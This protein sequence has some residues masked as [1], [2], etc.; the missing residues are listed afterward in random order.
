VET[1]ITQQWLKENS[2]L[3]LKPK[4]VADAILYSLQT[5]EYVLIKDL[6]I[7]PIR[8]I[9]WTP[10]EIVVYNVNIVIFTIK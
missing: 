10:N 1:E 9:I 7:A 6:V 5:P 4:D 8:E 2:R 3:A